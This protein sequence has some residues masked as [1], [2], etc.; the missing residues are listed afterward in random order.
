MRMLAMATMLLGAAALGDELKPLGNL[1]VTLGD[2]ASTGSRHRVESGK[3][4]AVA[5]TPT[6]SAAELR[7]TY[8]GPSAVTTALASGQVRRQIGVKL[9]AADS[10]NVLYVMWRL[11]PEAKLVVSLKRNPGMHVHAE[12]GTRGYA[13]LAPAKSAPLPAVTVGARH[14]LRATLAGT[15][16]SVLVDGKEV[17]SGAVPPETLQLD[18]PVGLRTD[19]GRFDF[20][21]L[22]APGTGFA[23]ARC[24]RGEGD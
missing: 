23:S 4:R 16:L 18:G 24:V 3:M 20:E 17:W 1:C 14:T 10:C 11:E 8:L 21:L 15:Q 12:C 5:A 9:R 22:A 6:G 2:V 19:N 13:N 7:F